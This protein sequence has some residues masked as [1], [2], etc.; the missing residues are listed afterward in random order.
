MLVTTALAVA[1]AGTDA[2]CLSGHVPLRSRIGWLNRQFL[3]GPVGDIGEQIRLA[4]IAKNCHRLVRF[5]RP[6]GL[7]KTGFQED[8]P[9]LSQ[10][11][12]TR[13]WKKI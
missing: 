10:L 4:A 9:C 7:H 12:P 1:I 11:T 6:S 5:F 2:S 3:R 8:K 13:P